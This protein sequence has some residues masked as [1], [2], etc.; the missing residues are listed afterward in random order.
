MKTDEILKGRK[1][2]KDNRNDTKDEYLEKK[3]KREKKTDVKLEKKKS[4]VILFFTY[5]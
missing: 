3:E 2:L 5:K 4:F 1:A